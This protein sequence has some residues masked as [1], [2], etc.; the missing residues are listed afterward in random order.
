[1]DNVN[2]PETKLALEYI[3]KRR[4]ILEDLDKKH[5]VGKLEKERF[6]KALRQSYLNHA[7]K[8]TRLY[9]EYETNMLKFCKDLG[10]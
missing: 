6:Y 8:N 7:T 10:I 4:A 3:A 2:T 5:V 9:D 1:M